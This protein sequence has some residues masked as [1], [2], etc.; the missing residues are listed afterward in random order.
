MKTCGDL[1][2]APAFPRGAW[3]RPRHSAPSLDLLAQ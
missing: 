3:H 1:T 2:T